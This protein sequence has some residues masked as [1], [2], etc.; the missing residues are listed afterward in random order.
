MEHQEMGTASTAFP[1]NVS[2]YTIL[3]FSGS[4]LPD[5]YKNLVYS[6]WLRS[7]RFGNDYFKLI[8]SDSYYSTY[9]SYIGSVLSRP[10]TIVRLAVLTEDKDV[11]F[12][13]SIAEDQQEV[14]HYVHVHKDTR[15]QGIAT[16]LLP[17]QWSVIT[18]ITKTAMSIWQS[19]YSKVIF[20]PFK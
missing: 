17:K 1:Q 3:T 12:G 8:D 4:S 7:L 2:S 15:K 6:K 20:N 10:T 16:S 19:K 9:H 18:H 13:F 5:S 14:L 11:V